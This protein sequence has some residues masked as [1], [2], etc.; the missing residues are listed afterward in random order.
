MIEF[1]LILGLLFI[2][3]IV[4]LLHITCTTDNPLLKQS[5]NTPVDPEFHVWFGLIEAIPFLS[6]LYIAGFF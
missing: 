1:L 3:G 6:T 2:L 5:Y 4:V